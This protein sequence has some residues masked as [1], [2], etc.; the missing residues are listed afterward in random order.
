MFFSFGGMTSHKVFQNFS[1]T[2][3]AIFES[4]FS[5]ANVASYIE[6]CIRN[7]SGDS[8]DYAKRMFKYRHLGISYI[9]VVKVHVMVSM[10]VLSILLFC[11]EFPPSP[12]SNSLGVIMLGIDEIP[13]IVAF[14]NSYIKETPEVFYYDSQQLCEIMS[15]NGSF[16]IRLSIEP[17][18]KDLDHE[19]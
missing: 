9:G 5:N 17:G 19:Y 12:H 6:E 3:D 18:G 2:F 11:K 16:L 4:F 10:P 15:D 13:N 8:F 7:L 1:K 14:Y